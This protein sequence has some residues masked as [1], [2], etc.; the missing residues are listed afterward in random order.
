MIY[1][2]TYT[3]EDRFEQ[4]FDVKKYYFD[5][6]VERYLFVV[7]DTSYGFTQRRMF[8]DIAQ[9]DSKK[10]FK[11]YKFIRVEAQDVPEKLLRTA[12][13][14]IFERDWK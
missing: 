2:E 3:R 14:L 6:G 5:P 12:F 11:D 1:R 10:K 8:L 7:A 9:P 4:D 13:E